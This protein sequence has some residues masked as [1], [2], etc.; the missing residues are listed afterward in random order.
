[1]RLTGAHIRGESQALQV[2]KKAV[3]SGVNFLDTADYYGQDVTNRL[4]A[5]AL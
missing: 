1:M 3:D 5:E 4:I 2:L